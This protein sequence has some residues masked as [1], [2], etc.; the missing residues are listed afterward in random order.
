MSVVMAATG[1][2]IRNAIVIGIDIGAAAVTGD[3]TGRLTEEGENTVLVAEAGAL[4]VVHT[5][6]IGREVRIGVGAETVEDT[7]TTEDAVIVLIGAGAGIEEQGMI[8][9]EIVRIV[10]GTYEYMHGV[11]GQQN[12]LIFGTVVYSSVLVAAHY[13]Y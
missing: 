10:L 7:T 1:N 3:V 5:A 11:L 2:V 4:S 12:R 13:T 6:M 9:D 8:D